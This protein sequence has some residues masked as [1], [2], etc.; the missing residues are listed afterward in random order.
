[1]IGN[2]DLELKR[3]MGARDE[4]SVERWNYSSERDLDFSRKNVYKGE[5]EQMEVW[6]L[7]APKSHSECALD[8]N[9]ASG[10]PEKIQEE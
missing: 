4:L 2:R 10:T 8:G 7:Q 9:H 5:E 1:M 3:E 6:L